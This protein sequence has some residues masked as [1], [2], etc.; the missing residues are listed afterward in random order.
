MEHIFVV[1]IYNEDTDNV[2]MHVTKIITDKIN[3]TQESAVA[4]QLAIK[5][6]VNYDNFT[7]TDKDEFDTMYNKAVNKF[8]VDENLT[9]F[10]NEFEC[11]CNVSISLPL[12][13]DIK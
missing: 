11:F 7:K 1:G 9:K 8:N 12:L 6:W 4:I 13:I 10:K 5:E 2:T 3:I